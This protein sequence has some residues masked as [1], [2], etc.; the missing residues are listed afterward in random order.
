MPHRPAARRRPRTF[1]TMESR[2]L[3]AADLSAAAA[4]DPIVDPILHLPGSI[5]GRVVASVDLG[6]GQSLDSGI[7]G[8]RLELLSAAG[9]ILAEAVTNDA[10][11]YEFPALEPGVYGIRELQPAGF[12]DGLAQV[13]SGSGVLE[14]NLITEIV[15]HSG[16]QLVGYDFAE[17]P[18][19]AI[20]ASDPVNTP[21]FVGV[22]I[23]PIIAWSR[24]AEVAVPPTSEQVANTPP[25][26]PPLV[27]RAA[28]P[29]FGGSSDV[30]R[31]KELATD[32]VFSDDG[33][34]AIDARITISDQSAE[35][36]E[37]TDDA[38]RGSDSRLRQAARDQTFES[39]DEPEAIEAPDA[40]PQQ[41]H[42]RIARK[43]AA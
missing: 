5:A 11:S 36:A 9:E 43:P 29:I 10:G 15:V 3:L 42:V 4:P 31:D 39:S 8:V 24:P 27:M 19:P 30:P 38:E 7:S 13:G 1:E 32:A 21:L 6:E 14:S 22:I 25:S 20:A 37:E 12:L 35:E 18:E 16:D 41:T 33:D 40:E 26:L 17:M 34:E 2:L 23:S 28:D